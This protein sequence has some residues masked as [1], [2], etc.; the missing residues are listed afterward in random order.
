M[1]TI[2][3]YIRQTLYV[4]AALVVAACSGHDDTPEEVEMIEMPVNIAIPSDGFSSPVDVG[5]DGEPAEGGLT[6][7][8]VP[9]DPGTVETFELPRYIYLFLVTENQGTSEVTYRKFGI[10]PQEW[11]LSTSADNKND[12]F[13]AEARDGLYVYQGHLSLFVPREREKG[14]VYVAACNVDLE[15][16][17]LNT[18]VTSA[19]K[20]PEEVTFTCGG[21]LRNNMKNLYSTPYNLKNKNGD[22]YGTIEDFAGNVPH[23]DIVLYHTATKFDVQ[24]QIDEDCQGVKEWVQVAKDN[25][26]DSDNM[27]SEEG[28]KVFF[29]Y[30][31]ACNI[32][33]D[34]CPLFMPMN[35]TAGSGTFDLAFHGKE[36]AT[37]GTHIDNENKERTDYCQVMPKDSKGQQYNGRSVIYAIPQRYTNSGDYFLTLRLL[38][39]N[40]TTA[41][42]PKST[43]A[44]Y[45]VLLRQED[46]A[47]AGHHAY[48]RIKDEDLA[49]ADGSPVFTPWVRAFIHVTKDNVGK[50]V[51]FNKEADYSAIP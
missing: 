16:Y 3:R 26:G 2:F 24:W 21:E 38:V 45:K 44:G 22:Y 46:H 36:V 48:I 12:H 8:V 11:K 19:D 33:K 43:D 13:S 35:F 42:S 25:N 23:L 31:E 27:C 40:Y 28:D 9:G 49:T 34:G 14:R 37:G 5:I 29:S 17:S 39:N 4:A 15:A 30:I 1:L 41:S 10:N 47:T 18:N 51:K 7:A 20:I 50:L 6:R 32:P